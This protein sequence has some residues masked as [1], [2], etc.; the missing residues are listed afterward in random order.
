MNIEVISAG[1]RHILQAEPGNNL[2]ECLNQAGLMEGSECGGR[3]ICGKCAVKILSGEF[4]PVSGKDA[5]GGLFCKNGE[6]LACRCLVTGDAVIELGS[7]RDNV[8]R[9]VH[10]PR[11]TDDTGRTEPAVTKI[12]I[13]ME[14]PS[15]IDQIS[16]IE[17]VLDKLPEKTRFAPGVLTSL[18]SILRSLD[19]KVTCVLIEDE[20]IAVEAGDTRNKNYGFIIDIGTTT[21]AIYL[22]DMNKGTTIDVQGLANPQRIHGSDVLSRITAASAPEGLKKLQKLIVNGISETMRKVCERNSIP[23]QHI[24]DIA[25]VGNTTMSHLFLGVDPANLAMAPFVPGYRPSFAVKAARLGLPMQQE[26]YVH[27]LANISGYVGSDTLGVAMAVKPW[28]QKGISLGVDI[29][30]NGE[31]ILG[32]KDWMLACSAA[33]GPAFEGAHIEQGMRAGEGAIEK[34]E[35][36][37]G[38]VTIGVIG[39]SAPQGICGSGLIDVVAELLRTG[40]L[41]YRGTFITEQDTAFN[42]PLASRIRMGKN[43]IREFVIAYAG[44]YGN[45]L[46]IIITQ[47]DIRELQL[48][49]AAIAAGIE[50][51]LKEAGLNSSNVDRLYL[52]GAFG[53]YL[54]RE[55][56]VGIGLFPGISV[57]K[58]IPVGNAAAEGA[59]MCLVSAAQ[60]KLSDNIAQRIKPVELSTHPAFKD[61]WIRSMLFLRKDKIQPEALQ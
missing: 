16:D 8:S 54:D 6:V 22:V 50:V 26:A 9:K 36:K 44:E 57:E 48:A 19:F 55:K 21:V 39:K 49:K 11:L 45:S 3:G 27:I 20:L 37:D 60:R 32:C 30:T 35:L 1:K 59:G 52:A 51:L 34:V 43:G 29:G 14:K 4:M 2:M 28:E 41:T 33:A 38:K 47:K 17:R 12:F 13:S 10:L 42:Q 5:G 46:D 53:N 58:I 31:I 25:V 18:P 24:Y 15:L 40:L 56:A 61:L 7:S 23:A